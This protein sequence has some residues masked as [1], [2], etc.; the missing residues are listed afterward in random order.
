MNAKRSL[1][2]VVLVLATVSAAWASH[3]L[4]DTLSFTD[5]HVIVKGEAAAKRDRPERVEAPSIQ[6]GNFRIEVPTLAAATFIPKPAAATTP[7]RQMLFRLT[8]Q[9]T[10]SS[11][12]EARFRSLVSDG[13][14]E[15]W[16][17]ADAG[18]YVRSLLPPASTGEDGI[19]A[20]LSC[21]QGCENWV[22]VERRGVKQ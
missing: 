8:A 6:L 3:T 5:Q 12:D 10:L 16:A 20:W 13:Q 17:P 2:Q 21:E 1:Q 15:V 7:P 9:R 19:H 22:W 11:I 4:A 18:M 14:A